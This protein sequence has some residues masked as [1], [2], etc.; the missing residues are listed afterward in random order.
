MSGTKPESDLNRMQLAAGRRGASLGSHWLED[1][2]HGLRLAQRAPAFAVAVVLLVALGIG[3]VTAVFSVV[4]AVLLTPLPYP[5]PERLA[6]LWETESDSALR[7]PLSGPNF[8]DWYE[9]TRSFQALAAFSPHS[10]S[11]AGGVEPE[12]ILGATMTRELFAVLDAEPALGRT[13]LPEEEQVGGA[14]VVVLSNR[15]WKRNFAGSPEILGETIVLDGEA[16]TVIGVM[17]PG[18]DVVSPWT[19]GRAMELWTPLRL[20]SSIDE[21]DSHWLLVFGR[22]ADGVT[23]ERAQ[24][25]MEVITAGIEVRYPETNTGHGARVAPLH[26]ELVGRIGGQLLM[27]LAAAGFVMLIVCAN[28]GG[29]LLAKTASR[30]S[31]LAVRASL[32]ASR[33]RLLRQLLIENLPLVLLGAIFGVVLAGWGLEVLRAFIPYAIVQAREIAV[34]GWVLAFTAVIALLTAVLLG[35]A[36]AL[37]ASRTNLAGALHQGRRGGAANPGRTRARR[38]LITAQLALTLVLANGAALMLTSYGKLQRTDQGFDAK[39]VLTARLSFVGPRYEELEAVMAFFRDALPRLRSLPGVEAAA[40]TTKLPIEGGTNGRVVIE[41]REDDFGQEQGPLVERSLVMPGYFEAMGIRL[42]AGR[43]LSEQDVSSDFPVAVVNQAMVR[44]AWPDAD[45]IGKRFAYDPGGGWTTV[46]GV[47]SDVRQWGRERRALPEYYFPLASPPAYWGR[48]T[49]RV[50]GAFVVLRSAV[51]PRILIRSLK[52][53]IRSVDPQQP[54]SEIRT[55][56]Q[57][58]QS[59]SARRR[60]NTLL[61]ALFAGMGVILVAAGIFGLMSTFVTQRT[62]EI[63]VRM[64]L[65]ADTQGV[66]RLVIGQLIQLLVFGVLVGGIAVFASTRLIASLLYG[67]SPTEPLVLAGGTLFVALLAFMGSL[68]PA[69]RAARIDPVAALRTEN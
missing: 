41:G 40:A 29:L 1:T 5:S 46:V 31:E 67:V 59:A 33:G 62:Q 63:G 61:I 36:P 17:P 49:P 16:H 20:T 50:S 26:E 39:G 51:E 56:D 10:Y 3:A 12:R 14:P 69:L 19:P 47:V 35:L 66:L 45:P 68:V 57:I 27:L 22:L 52:E 11:L 25:E 54:V 38:L 8:L 4:K 43:L 13:F 53:E 21:R 65:G 48:W 44:T 42:I 58:L 28:V 60:F 6:I 64:A 34:D 7:I 18:F 30:E 24:S 32:G 23:L 15:L 2:R 9:S 55:M 37:A